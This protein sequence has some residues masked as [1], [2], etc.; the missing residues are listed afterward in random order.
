MHRRSF[1]TTFALC[2]VLFVATTFVIN[3]GPLTP[4]TGPVSSTGRFG[5]RVDVLTLAGD[6]DSVHRI[7]EPG[8]YYLSGNVV[9]AAGLNGIEIFA[10]NVTLD[11]NGFAVIGEVGSLNGIRGQGTNIVVKNGNVSDWG[12]IGVWVSGGTSRVENVQARDNG[13]WGFNVAGNFAHQ[14]IACTAQANGSI[15]PD[16][17]G[18]TLGCDTTIRD[19]ISMCNTGDGIRGTFRCAIYQNNITFNTGMGINLTGGDSLIRGNM[20]SAN[21]TGNN[22]MGST[23]INNRGI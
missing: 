10:S 6:A 4:P 9:G 17:G 1:A 3:A 2:C 15:N 20:V 5:P 14:V 7:T 23:L 11:L 19:S 13:S 18:F 16:A 8:S 21:T 12:N 22:P